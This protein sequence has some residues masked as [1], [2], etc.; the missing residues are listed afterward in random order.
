MTRINL[1][2]PKLLLDQ[3][4]LAEH[5]EIKRLPK[6]YSKYLSSKNKTKIPECYLFGTG[7][8]TFFFNK[9][10]F[11]F[12]RYRELYLECLTRKFK[13]EDY[14]SS[15]TEEYLSSSFSFIPT[16]LEIRLSINRIEDKFSLKPLWY[17]YYGKTIEFSYLSN[18]HKFL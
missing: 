18:L 11:V 8:V 4:L 2:P 6:N 17:E 14:S 13:V 7:H 10:E 9:G 12:N 16:E 1:I 3:H 15:F 5:R